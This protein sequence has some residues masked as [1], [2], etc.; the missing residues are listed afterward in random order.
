MNTSCRRWAVVGLV[1]VVAA[2][3][4]MDPHSAA[5]PRE[6]AFEVRVTSGLLSLRASGA[7]LADVLMAV[8]RQ[9]NLKI[10]LRGA[11][12][13]LV[14]DEFANMPLDK[15]VRRLTR[16][17]SVVLVY[18]GPRDE[19]ADAKLA[20]VWVTSA[21]SGRAADDN[22]G[23][24]GSDGFKGSTGVQARPANILREQE[25]DSRPP[26]LTMAL[27]FGPS[28]SRTQI[29]NALVRERGKYAVID[30]LREAATRDPNPR[31]R[32]GA[33]QVLASLNSPEAVEAVQA[34]LHDEH[35]GV[36][37]EAETAL[38]RLRQAQAAD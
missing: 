4:P 8:G 37:G 35:P 14:T 5:G 12:D 6:T 23:G 25:P 24:A 18:G 34:T 26:G 13:S 31:I 30:I 15:A 22:N 19:A 2:A 32:R 21:P 33:I 16:W 3:I 7:Q 38:R 17:H 28:D 1:V 27:R 10:V 11:I 36:R 20:E 29:I 9:A